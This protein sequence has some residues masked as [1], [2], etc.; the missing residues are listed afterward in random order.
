MRR[1]GFVL[2]LVALVAAGCSDDKKTTASAT[3]V[4]VSVDNK[5]PFAASFLAYFPNEVT[6]HPGDTVQFNSVFTGEPHS[7]S[8]GTLVD[9]GLSAA[10][11]QMNNPDFDPST[12]PQLA[13]IPPMLPEGP[14]DAN[15]VS[16]APCYVDTGNPPGAGETPCPNHSSSPPEFT[17]KQSFFS[18][19]FLG[20]GEIYNVKLASDIAPGT[21]RYFCTLHSIGMQGK[22]TVVDSEQA[23]PSE[24]DNQ[25]AAAQQLE[26]PIAALTPG[27][28]AAQSA[29]PDKA[30][31]GVISEEAQ[32]ASGNVFGAKE[33]SVPV[34]GSVT[35]TLLGPHTISFNTPEDAKVVIAKA[36][37]GLVHLNPKAFTPEGGGVPQPQGPPGGGGGETTSTT[38]AAGNTST[39]ARA[40]TTTTTASTSTSAAGGG[41]PAPTEID[42]GSFAGTGFYNT[43]IYFSFPPTD[44]FSYKLSFTKAG[45]YPYVCLI[46]PGMEGTVKVG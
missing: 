38:A 1:I 45:T 24:A 21:Y 3:T 2:I 28:E 18:S 30:V 42:G 23:I 13:A 11:A 16:A 39:S 33:L 46:H 9:Q 44:L 12:I 37:D 22:I 31:A 32:E 14:G 34:N 25:A 8:L 17:G 4:K 43:G 20:N 41:P 10:D 7:V 15:Q 40:T 5:A 35:W 19:G 29:P 6:V 26:K 36:P 27:I